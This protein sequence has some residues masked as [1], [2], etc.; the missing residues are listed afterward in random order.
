MAPA[1]GGGGGVG[2]LGWRWRDIILC[3]GGRNTD[4]KKWRFDQTEV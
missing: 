3:Y 4:K 2:G 1:G